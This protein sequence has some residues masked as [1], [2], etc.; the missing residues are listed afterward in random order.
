MKR[1]FLL[2]SSAGIEHY[3]I[4]DENGTSFEAVAPTD[5][6]IEQN[7]AMRNHNDGYSPSREFRRVAIIP[8]ILIQKWRNE[9][10][11]DVY[12][13]DHADKLAQKLNDPDYAFLRTAD[14]HIGYSNGVMR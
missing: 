2:R 5:P 1:T 9:E 3:M 13:P 8:E 11:W 10:G 14:G 12:N 6:I 4:E 7:K